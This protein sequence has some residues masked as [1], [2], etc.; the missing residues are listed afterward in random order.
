LRL[1]ERLNEGV[2]VTLISAPAGFGKTTLVSE[3]VAHARVPTA[4]LYLDEG[5]NDLARFLVYFV[6][7][8]Q[9]I[10]AP[11][12]QGL[13]ESL[14]SNQL[15]PISSMMTTLINQ[16]AAVPTNF[17]LILDDYHVI[18]NPSIDQ[19]IAFLID[20]LP[21]SMRLIIATRRSG[22]APGSTAGARSDE[23]TASRRL[24]IHPRRG[25]ELS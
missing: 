2:K 1:L 20:Y 5:D 16:I 24:E 4:W 18:E 21:L 15:P 8:L 3:W 11:I 13:L 22:F 6:A 7:A 14:E 9:T 17:V 23:R 19:A 10:G 25:R 12:G